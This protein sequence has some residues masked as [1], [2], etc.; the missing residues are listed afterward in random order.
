[1]KKLENKTGVPVNL[2]IDEL[3]SDDIRKRINSVKNLNLIASTIGPERARN[4]LV[5]FLQELLD[6]EDEVLAELVDSLANSF[7]EYLG[8]A[9]H[10]VQLVP[11]LESLCKVEDPVVREKAALQLRKVFS[12]DLK[13]QEEQVMGLMRRLQDNDYYM[14]KSSL[15]MLLPAVIP[16][17]SSSN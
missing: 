6:D 3:K 15:A 12:G 14:S 17:L 11:L 5:P 16:Q 8:G 10:G 7:T 2:L 9:Q 13:K 1:M 4:E